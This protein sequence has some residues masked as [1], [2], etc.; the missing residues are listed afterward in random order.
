MPNIKPPFKI[1]CTGFLRRPYSLFAFKYR[2]KVPLT[3]FRN[4]LQD[5]LLRS[6]GRSPFLGG[7]FSGSAFRNRPTPPAIFPFSGHLQETGGFFMAAA[8]NVALKNQSVKATPQPL[9]RIKKGKNREMC[10]P[11]GFAGLAI[12]CFG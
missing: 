10:Q 9:I 4:V 11:C 2:P 8:S 1:S 7:Y 6:H 12:T 3:A 5:T